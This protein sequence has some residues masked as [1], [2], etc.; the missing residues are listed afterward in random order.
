M[1][2]AVVSPKDRQTGKTALSL[3][4]VNAYPN[5]TGKE[6]VYVTNSS[7]NEALTLE[8]FTATTVSVEKSINVLTVLSATENLNK[9]DILDYA[10]RPIN[11]NAMLFDIFSEIID[12]DEAKGNFIS[13]VDKL[14]SRFLVMDLNGDPKSREVQSLMDEC[15]VVLYVIKPTKSECDSAREFFDSLDVDGRAKTKLIC[16]LW[17]ELG[18]KKTTIQEHIKMR[19][20]SILWFPYHRNIQR[21]MFESRLCVLNRLMIEGRDQC[22]ALRQPIKDILSFI[23]DTPSIKVVREVSKWEL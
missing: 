23:C 22:V 19:A 15:D 12:F 10:Y 11:T 6:S 3:M 2:V 5:A 1:R 17:D 4:L 8:Q 18:I 20:N 21:T 16:N 7:L 14:G 9:D 13:V